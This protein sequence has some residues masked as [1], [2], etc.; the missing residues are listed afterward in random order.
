MLKVLWP[1]ILTGAVLVLATVVIWIFGLAYADG[2]RQVLGAALVAQV[3]NY[4]AFA[5][6]IHRYFDL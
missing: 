1:M 5:V 2:W 3:V 6:V 4:T